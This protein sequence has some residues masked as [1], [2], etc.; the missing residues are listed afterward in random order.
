MER[1]VDRRGPGTDFTTAQREPQLLAGIFV[2]LLLNQLFVPNHLQQLFQLG[3]PS[4]RQLALPQV[5][6]RHLR[7]EVES[8]GL[9]EQ[10]GIAL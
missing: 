2:T 9:V 8:F 7:G 3:A 1:R 5:E 10:R 4:R 6:A